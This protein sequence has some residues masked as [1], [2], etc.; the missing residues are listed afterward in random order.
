MNDRAFALIRLTSWRDLSII[1]ES[2]DSR[3]WWSLSSLQG[4]A[5]LHKKIQ[6]YAAHQCGVLSRCRL[7]CAREAFRVLRKQA[8]RRFRTRVKHNNSTRG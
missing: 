5:M 8:A 7:M 1:Q 4:F 3:V 2:S 6:A